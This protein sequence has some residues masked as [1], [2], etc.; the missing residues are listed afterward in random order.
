MTGHLCLFECICYSVSVAV[1]SRVLCVLFCFCLCC[2]YFFWYFYFQ[3]FRPNRI[4]RLSVVSAKL[5]ELNA[6]Q[7]IQMYVSRPLLVFAFLLYNK[8]A[9]KT[10]SVYCLTSILFDFFVLLFCCCCCFFFFFVFYTLFTFNCKI[11]TILILF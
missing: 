6:Y 10:S 11:V 3:T 1:F 9:A 5:T 7:Y 4:V 2:I 8:W